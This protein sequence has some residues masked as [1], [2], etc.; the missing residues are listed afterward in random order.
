M[1]AGTSPSTVRRAV[2]GR[3]VGVLEGRDGR[4]A[5]DHGCGSVSTAPSSSPA[6][7]AATAAA[8]SATEVSSATTSRRR[9]AGPARR[10]RAPPRTGRGTPRAS[11]RA[12]PARRRRRARRPV[13]QPR[14]SVRSARATRRRAADIRVRC[15]TASSWPRRAST[16]R[17]AGA[18]GDEPL[19]RHGPGRGEDPQRRAGSRWSPSGRGRRRP[20]PA[21]PAARRRA[22]ARRAGRRGTGRAPPRTAAG[23]APGTRAAARR[24]RGRTRRGPPRR[25]PARG[26]TLIT[27]A[28]AAPVLGDQ[29]VG[30]GRR[31]AGRRT[32]PDARGRRLREGGQRLVDPQVRG[33]RVRQ[34]SGTLRHARCT[35][36]L[37]RA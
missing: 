10:S 22:A 14:R 32:R 18:N 27:P 26:G 34:R 9:A 31:R 4:P 25:A 28:S 21:T 7:S 3:S 29:P 12:P 33:V 35:V 15:T 24:P 37:P 36:G 17:S 5:V 30:P 13:A 11:G 6:A 20:A 1:G 19:H 2:T 8:T 16:T 23:T